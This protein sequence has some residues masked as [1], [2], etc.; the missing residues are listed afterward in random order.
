MQSFLKAFAA[1]AILGYAAAIANFIGTLPC[2]RKAKNI[3]YGCLCNVCKRLVGQERLVRRNDNVG[4]RDQSC[5]DVILEDVSRE[6]LKEEV[7]FFLVNVKASRSHVSGFDGGKQCLGIDQRTARGVDK[8]HAATAL[9]NRLLVDHVVGLLGERTVQRNNITARK[10]LVKLDV[11]DGVAV[12]KVLCG[13]FIVCQ[14]LHAKAAADV[15]KHAA[16]LARA[17]DA[18]GLAVQVKACHVVEAEVK[19]ARADIRLVDAADRGEQHCH[20]VLGDRIGRVGGDA[21]NVDLAK[22]IAHV[23]VVE[24][25]AAQGDHTDAHFAKT[26]DDGSVDGVV[27]KHANTIATVS[28]INGVLVELGFIVF[29]ANTRVLSNRLKRL[30]IVRLGIKKSEF[31][32]F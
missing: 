15:D 32:S 3:I 18:N 4:H 5:Q 31:H 25:R 21:E 27:D 12:V 9:R 2:L 24:A 16:D 29:K 28:E 1:A 30:P 13:E 22:G 17:N 8:H 10:E 19:V 20:G 7:G 23:N 14:H 6:I 26:V 11:A